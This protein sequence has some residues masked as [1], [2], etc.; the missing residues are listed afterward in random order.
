MTLRAPN[1]TSLLHVAVA[2]TLALGLGACSRSQHTSDSL[3]GPGRRG[4][5]G[6][7]FGIGTRAVDSPFVPVVPCPGLIAAA[8][9]APLNFVATVAMVA[10][11]R[12]NRLRIE[13][14]GEIAGPSL[15]DMGPCAAADAPS[16]RFIGGHANLFF[17]G[18]DTSVTIT[19]QPLEFGPLFFPGALIEPGIVLA[20]DAQ[21]DVLEIIWPELAGL[22]PGD[23]I[24]RVQLSRWNPQLLTTS[25][26]YDLE[27]DM[28]AERDGVQMTFKGRSVNVGLDGAA[29]VQEGGTS[30]PPPCPQTLA[31]TSDAVTGV[32][33]D[34]VQFRANRLRLEVIGDTPG[35]IIDATGTCAATDQASIFF[36]G[37]SA[38]LFRAGTN[39]SVTTTSKPIV[40][41]PL[42]FPGLAVEPGIVLATDASNNVLEIIWPGLAGLG[43]GLPILRLQLSG[44]N[45][46]VRTGKLVD[47]TMRFDAAAADGIPASYTVVARNVL[48]PTLR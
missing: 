20:I 39:I 35:G 2:L 4:A 25:R 7:L 27:W 1:P 41:G 6:S 3:T 29:V 36:T 23:P 17:H 33:A 9:D 45:S 10:Q 37:G 43:P 26:T 47:A 40:F 18:T 13:S 46:W 11:F 38:N 22:G 15:K 24:V 19:G 5:N 12:T 21:N 34:I 14:I 30:S 31:N 32:F 28:T 44:W 42:F 16:I 8:P 48:V